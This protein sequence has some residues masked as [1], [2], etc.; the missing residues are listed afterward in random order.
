[1]R[2]AKKGEPLRI[3]AVEWNE[4]RR[5]ARQGGF[6]R[7]GPQQPSQINTS[8]IQ[9]QVK[10]GTGSD[11][12]RGD[13]VAVYS[14]LFTEDENFSVYHTGALT[15]VTPIWPDDIGT[16]AVLSIPAEDGQIVP[17]T[18][19]GVAP[20]T[21]FRRV[22]VAFD[23]CDVLDDVT[24]PPF[25]PGPVTAGME[26]KP[27]GSAKIIWRDEANASVVATGREKLPALVI[28]GPPREAE[29][30]V[31]ITEPT[32]IVAGGSGEV[33]FYDNGV[34]TGYKFDAKLDW[35]HGGKAIANGLQAM[36]RWI[37]RYQDWRLRAAE[38]P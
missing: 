24:G 18:I 38:C 9:V 2:E 22:D 26:E 17:A 33:E 29:L 4:V 8:P 16:L 7:Q 13:V 23:W 14:P 3:E 32:E 21:L 12:D 19:R 31:V 15:G 10:N 5:H 20:I 6:G 36:V 34:A 11:L 25:Y 27:Q 30:E 37:H 35:M 28:L 1:M